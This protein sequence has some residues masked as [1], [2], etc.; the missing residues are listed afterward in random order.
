MERKDIDL[1]LEISFSGEKTLVELV[2]EYG[3]RRQ[4]D[5][6]EEP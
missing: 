1:I 3:K 6:E 4:D 2:R 5:E